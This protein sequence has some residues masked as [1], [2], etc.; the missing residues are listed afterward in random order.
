[1]PSISVDTGVWLAD[2]GAQNGLSLFWSKPWL[3]A[4]RIVF[5]S[6]EPKAHGRAYRIPILRRPSVVR[7]RSYV[8]TSSSTISNIFSETTYPIKVKFYVEPPWV[9]GGGGAKFC[10]RHL[11]HMTKMA[12][13][14]KYGENLS[15]IFFSQTGGSISTKLSM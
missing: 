15:K 5:S 1:M 13:T 9:E 7:R 10:S 12:A 3:H 4:M 6:P 14:P 2:V 11:G 8:P